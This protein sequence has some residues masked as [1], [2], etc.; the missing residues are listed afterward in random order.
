MEAVLQEVLELIELV[1]KDIPEG[2][3]IEIC[4]KMKEVHDKYK[5]SE[6]GYQAAVMHLCKLTRE[7]AELK[8]IINFKNHGKD[9]SDQIKIPEPLPFSTLLDEMVNSTESSG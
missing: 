1:S 7:N 2:K 9:Q 8:N 3:Y 5:T 6:Y 4:N